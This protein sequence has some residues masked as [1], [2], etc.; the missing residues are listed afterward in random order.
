M[1]MFPIFMTMENGEERALAEDL[2]LTYRSRMYGIAY[3]ILHHREDAE[4]AVMDAVFS[5]V[6]NISLF[7]SVPRNK[8][9]SLIVVI[10]R[11]AAINRYNYN[12]RRRTSSLDAEAAKELP[13]R[14]PTPEELFGQQADYEALL[15][16]I[17]S[18]DPIYRDV[19]LLKYLYGYDNGTVAAVTGVAE[20]TVRVRLMRAKEKLSALLGGGKPD[21]TE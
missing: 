5:I 9:E 3:A 18:L 13:D 14:D 11:N 6:K 2:Y 10:V 16:V 20:A 8:T 19:L 4:D 12:R 1:L 15:R 7:S 21:G 17:R